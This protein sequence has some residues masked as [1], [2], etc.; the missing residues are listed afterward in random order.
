MNHFKIF[1]VITTILLLLNSCSKETTPTL[2]YPTSFKF[3]TPS[4][5]ERSVY[6][7]DSMSVLDPGTNTKKL[8]WTYTKL[9]EALGSYDKSSKEIADTINYLIR[10][11]FANRM[12][13]KITLL[14]STQMEIEYSTLIIND[15]S[16]ALMDQ[17]EY[18]G[19]EVID[20]QQVGNIL[21][22]GLYINNDSREL[23]MCN[24]F[25]LG[26]KKLTDTSTYQQYFISPD[27]N[28]PDPIRSLDRFVSENN[29]I[30]FDTASIEYVNYIFSSYK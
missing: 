22:N 25:I 17:I 12:I 20:Y 24:E 1:I 27:C 15:L 4:L 6:T 14:S 11:K 10:L 28:G 26:T 5:E 13:S 29:D 9:G 16:N 8:V 30:K 7:I 18:E 19:T 3:N 21:L 23:Y 2:T